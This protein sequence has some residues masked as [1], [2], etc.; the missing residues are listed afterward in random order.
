MLVHTTM[1]LGVIASLLAILTALSS[2]RIRAVLASAFPS[3]NAAIYR[4]EWSLESLHKAIGKAEKEVLILQTWLP[5]LNRGMDEWEK[6]SKSVSFRILLADEELV[7]ARLRCRPRVMPLTDMNLQRLQQMAEEAPGRFQVRLYSALPFGPVVVIDD[8][9]YWGIY[10]ADRDSLKGPK[11][12]TTRKSFLGKQILSSFEA[13]WASTDEP[14]PRNSL[15]ATVA[16]SKH[17]TE[18]TSLTKDA[19]LEINGVLPQGDVTARFCDNCNCW[20]DYRT[21]GDS[22]PVHEVESFCPNANCRRHN[23]MVQSVPVY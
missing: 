12:R 18:S 16:R 15:T 9:V 21:K 2:P 6:T 1:W 17:A 8:D 22:L 13:L 23:E 19:L 4:R 14:L 20:L 3:R 10:L 11:F 7:K 5:Y